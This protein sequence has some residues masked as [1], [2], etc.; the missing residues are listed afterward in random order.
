VTVA[1]PEA[2]AGPLARGL[3]VVAAGFVAMWLASFLV[4]PGAAGDHARFHGLL[5]GAATAVALALALALRA[6][7]VAMARGAPIVGLGLFAITQLVEAF[8]AFGYGPDGNSRVNEMVVLHD[9]G[10]S[11]S[12]VGLIGAIGGSSAG[13]TAAVAARSSRRGATAVAGAATIAVAL[14]L[15]AKM[16]GL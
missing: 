3:L 10:V 1:R 2:R 14:I 11:I 16:V 5:G 6:R 15:V 13:L 8:G 4:A 12:P 9:L 7:P